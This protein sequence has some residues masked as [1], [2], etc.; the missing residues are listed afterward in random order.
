M[1]TMTNGED[2]LTT[3]VATRDYFVTTLNDFTDDTCEDINYQ[4]QLAGSN[5]YVPQECIEV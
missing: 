1:T 4:E 2:T 5:M 3:P